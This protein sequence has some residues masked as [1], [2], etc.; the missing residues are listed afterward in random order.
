MTAL[1]T[2]ITS[3]FR[4]GRIIVPL[5][6][7]I[8]LVLLAVVLKNVLLVPA[9]QLSSDMILYIILYIGFI[10]SYPLADNETTGSPVRT[11]L[12]TGTC[13]LMTFGIIAVNAL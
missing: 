1:C 6:A 12:W 9:T 4:N 2:R 3:V 10:V 8:C 5:T 7:G 11:M 13:I